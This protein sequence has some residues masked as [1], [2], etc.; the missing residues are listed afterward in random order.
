MV[1]RRK[2]LQSAAIATG[3][4]G[5]AS[6]VTPAGAAQGARQGQGRGQTTEQ[7]SAEAAPKPAS[8]LQVPKMKF[9]NVEI[10]RL[11]LGCNQF[12]GFSHFN[13]LL[14][15][16]MREHYTPDRVCE[17]MHQCNR[18]GINAYNYRHTDRTHS[19]LKRFQ[20]EGGKMHLIIQELGDPVGVY[21]AVKPLAMFYMGEYTDRAFQDDTMDTVREWCKKARDTGTMVGI[22]TH[23]PEVIELVEEQGWDVDFYA[24]CVY[25]RTRTEDEWR[26]VLGGQIQETPNE[27]YLQSDPPKMY[28]VMRQIRKPCF[29]FKILAAGRI[30]RNPRP[31]IQGPQASVEQ[32]FRTAFESIKPND[33]I[34][35][36]MF[37]RVT[38]EV[39]ENAEHVVRTLAKA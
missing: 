11:V 33:G 24:G 19:D 3:L 14:G 25:N 1:T 4:T 8:E 29:A 12:L 28:K 13:N 2:F 9:G 18:F 7:G 26:E 15:A 10:S 39:R 17:V 5:A 38:D 31:S 23:K 16:I 37:P 32:A 6:T 35:V 27:T 34:F 20:A 30:S 22:G 21:K 36:G